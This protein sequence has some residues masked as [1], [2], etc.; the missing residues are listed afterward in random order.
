[1]TDGRGCRCLLEVR[2]EFF[3]KDRQ[4]KTGYAREKKVVVSG[5]DVEHE[6][7]PTARE[8]EVFELGRR[9]R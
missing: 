5:P 8:R 2:Q 7:P 6:F 3:G 9:G 4:S 1:V